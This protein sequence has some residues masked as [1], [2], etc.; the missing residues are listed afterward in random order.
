MNYFELWVELLR[1]QLL[2]KEWLLEWWFWWWGRQLRVIANHRRRTPENRN[3]SEAGKLSNSSLWSVLL[4][5]IASRFNLEALVFQSFPGVHAPRPPLLEG[6]HAS[7]LWVC[8]CFSRATLIFF[9]LLHPFMLTCCEFT[10][11][12]V[13][14]LMHSSY[15]TP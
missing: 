12:K 13:T 2:M 8:H 3:V 14:I 6:E 15:I 1:V 10:T 7:M 11:D 5:K 4:A 9:A